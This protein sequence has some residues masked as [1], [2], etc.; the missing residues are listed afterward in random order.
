V[1]DLHFDFTGRKLDERICERFGWAPLIRFYEDSKRALLARRRL[2]HEVF[3]RYPSARRATTL[4]FAVET[5]TSLSDVARR[6]RILHDQHLIAGHGHT[7]DAEDL[8]WNRRTSE[9]DCLTTLVKERANTT[10]E[11][12]AD[13]V[14]SD[15]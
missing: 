12:T 6:R 4:C 13:E 9:L 8:S 2:R 5:L 10:R 7:F 3:E 14:V 15:P 11:E 1:N